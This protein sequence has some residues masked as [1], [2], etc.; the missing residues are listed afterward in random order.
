[1]IKENDLKDPRYYYI[2]IV[3]LKMNKDTKFKSQKV[4]V[5]LHLGTKYSDTIFSLDD[6][7]H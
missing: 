5:K 2:Q 6:F 3:G 1:M 4:H 7:N